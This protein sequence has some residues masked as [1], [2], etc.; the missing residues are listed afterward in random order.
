MCNNRLP[1]SREGF[2]LLINW[3]HNPLSAFIVIL[4]HQCSTTGYHSAENITPLRRLQIST[5]GQV[6]IVFHPGQSPSQ[7]TTI[8]LADA[9]W[10]SR[11][12]RMP[13]NVEQ[14]DKQR[15]GIT[16]IRCFIHH[17]QTYVC[18]WAICSKSR[19]SST[20]GNV[21]WNNPRREIMGQCNPARDTMSFFFVFA[22]T[23]IVVTKWCF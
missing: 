2:E 12:G 8:I 10:P 11:C 22:S 15:T 21:H 3:E 14:R 6:R 4:I 20:S 5:D 18:S 17:S 13:Q 1:L 23:D 7:M 19:P 16:W 9:P